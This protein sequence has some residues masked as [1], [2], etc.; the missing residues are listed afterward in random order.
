MKTILFPFF[1]AGKRGPPLFGRSCLCSEPEHRLQENGS[2]IHQDIAV[3][4]GLLIL[5]ECSSC[6]LPRKKTSNKEGLGHQHKTV[7]HGVFAH[8]TSSLYALQPAFCRTF[9]IHTCELLFPPWMGS[10]TAQTSCKWKVEE[11]TQTACSKRS[12]SS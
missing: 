9:V 12:V 3:G 10:E 6:T 11:T 4:L 1:L 2:I 8:V 5:W 7:G